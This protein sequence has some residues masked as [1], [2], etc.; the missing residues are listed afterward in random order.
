MSY[1]GSSA[2]PSPVKPLMA[3]S[4]RR[5]LSVNKQYSLPEDFVHAGTDGHAVSWLKKLA[6]QN[7]VKEFISL[8]LY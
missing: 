2:T 5:I 4:N 1:S 8:S 6:E 7:G 3:T